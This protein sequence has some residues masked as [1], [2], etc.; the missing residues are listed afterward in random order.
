MTTELCNFFKYS[1][2]QGKV[3]VSKGERRFV[4]NRTAQSQW[5]L[6]H[7]FDGEGVLRYHPVCMKNMGAGIIE[8]EC[9]VQQCQ[10]FC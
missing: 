7:C 8:N 6:S 4:H 5:I 3:I 9:M 10:F 1:N 2:L